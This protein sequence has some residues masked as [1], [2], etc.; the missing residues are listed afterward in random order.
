MPMIQRYK[1]TIRTQQSAMRQLIGKNDFLR[2]D[3]SREKTYITSNQVNSQK[4]TFLN[5]RHENYV[6]NFGRHGLPELFDYKAMMLKGNDEA[7]LFKNYMHARETRYIEPIVDF[8]LYK[9]VDRQLSDQLKG[10]TIKQGQTIMGHAYHAIDRVI[11]TR[12]EQE[13]K[14]KRIG[15]TVASIKDALLHGKISVNKENGIFQIIGKRTRVIVNKYG[16][17]VTVLPKK[18]GR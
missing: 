14:K 9:E 17:I 15:V 6:K 10:L 2:R 3:Y 4:P 5:D 13:S 1:S 7:Q 16:L 18:G 8:E 12:Y 11:G